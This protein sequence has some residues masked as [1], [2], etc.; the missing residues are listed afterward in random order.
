MHIAR[1]GYGRSWEFKNDET[2]VSSSWG[3]STGSPTVVPFHGGPLGFQVAT[4]PLGATHHAGDSRRRA[5]L[6]D[7]RGDSERGLVNGK[8]WCSD[9]EASNAGL[10]QSSGKRRSHDSPALG[11]DERLSDSATYL[12]QRMLNDGPARAPIP[13]PPGGGSTL[14]G[15]SSSEPQLLSPGD[16]RSETGTYTV[17]MDRVDPAVEE[18]RRKIDEVFGV[19]LRTLPS[20]HLDQ[21]SRLEDGH[22]ASGLRCQGKVLSLCSKFG[23]GVACE[24]AKP[25]ITTFSLL[26]IPGP[27]FPFVQ[28]LSFVR[29]SCQ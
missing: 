13:E 4:T 24:Y 29:F 7:T 20:S 10:R 26:C 8:E 28:F 16:D 6:S 14:R 21:K 11:R 2:K 9:V 19:P 27:S 25:H 1:L 3:T 23:G 12:I 17:E 18:A 5:S 22:S 15:G